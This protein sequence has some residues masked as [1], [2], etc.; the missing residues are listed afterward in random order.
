MYKAEIM[1]DVMKYYII[2]AL[3]FLPFILL[4]SCDDDETLTQKGTVV[5]MDLEGGFYGISG[6]DGKNYDPMNLP[7]EYKQDSLRVEFK[8]KK[9]TDLASFHMWGTIIEIVEIKKL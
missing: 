7:G 4:A 1:R 6:D 5:Y 2:A 9:R 8:Y 3:M